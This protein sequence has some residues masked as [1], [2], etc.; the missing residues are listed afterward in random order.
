MNMKPYLTSLLAFATLTL[1]GVALAEPLNIQELCGDYPIIH[2]PE[3]RIYRG[4]FK[5]Q[6]NTMQTALVATPVKVSKTMIVFYLWGEQP[7][8]K[9]DEAG[10]VPA[11]ARWKSSRPCCG[12]STTWRKNVLKYTFTED[13]TQAKVKYNGP[14][15]ST[16]GEIHLSE[17]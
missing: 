8:W 15:G 3:N 1:P 6:G 2:A 12:A 9:I 11:V 17:N 7:K 13:A 5:R 16:S 4:E 10:C 14:R